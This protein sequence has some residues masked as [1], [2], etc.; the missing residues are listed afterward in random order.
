MSNK[1]NC[2]NTL[3][4]AHEFKRMCNEFSFC[5]NCPMDKLPCKVSDISETHINIVQEWSDAHPKI[6]LTAEQREVLKAML[7]LGFKYI[8]KDRSG[9]T[10]IYTAC[11]IKAYA[12]AM[13]TCGGEHVTTAHL[14][15]QAAAAIPSL[16]NWED[17]EPLDIEEVLKNGDNI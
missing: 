3:D 14:S 17:K 16:V 5:G 10:Y 15:T 11:P 4:Y 7:L 6:R 8:A 9:K 1:Y 2:N 12:H 13:W